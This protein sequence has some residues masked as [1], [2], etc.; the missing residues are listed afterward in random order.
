MNFYYKKSSRSHYDSSYNDDTY[1]DN[2]YNDN[3]YN[4]NTYNDNTYNDNTYNSSYLKFWC[5]VAK[6]DSPPQALGHGE[7]VAPDRVGRLG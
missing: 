2:T 5:C 7:H 4:D 1:N 6:R 3:P